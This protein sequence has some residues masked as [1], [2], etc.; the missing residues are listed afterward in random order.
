MSKLPDSAKRSMSVVLTDL[1]LSMIVS[2][3]TSIRPI[4]LGSMLYF[5]R[6]PETANEEEVKTECWHDS[7]EYAH[8]SKQR[9]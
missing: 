3:P 2:V 7:S 4:D 9:N 1:D 5:S 6:R 8:H